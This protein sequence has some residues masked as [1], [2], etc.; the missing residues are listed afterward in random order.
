MYGHDRVQCI[1]MYHIIRGQSPSESDIQFLEIARKLELYG[2][3][4]FDA[5][6]SQTFLT[7][8]HWSIGIPIIP[9]NIISKTVIIFHILSCT[10]TLIRIYTPNHWST[11][12]SEVCR[13]AA[14]T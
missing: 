1:N 13:L 11:P 9:D 12:C 7:S 8:L 14:D 10:H 5:V 4:Q 2:I 3:H 6:V